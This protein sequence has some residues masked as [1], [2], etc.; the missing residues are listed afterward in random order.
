MSHRHDGGS[1]HLSN[2]GQHQLDYMA[3]HPRRLESSYSLPR[4]P[5][6]SN[7][8]IISLSEDYNTNHRTERPSNTVPS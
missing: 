6:I 5:E 2:I 4:D 8:I 1:M 7:L 3:L